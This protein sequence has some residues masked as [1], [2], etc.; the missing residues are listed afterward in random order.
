MA[1]SYVSVRCGKAT[2]HML[3]SREIAT[4]AWIVVKEKVE[5]TLIKLLF[6][7]KWGKVVLEN[8]ALFLGPTVQ[9]FTYFYLSSPILPTVIAIQPTKKE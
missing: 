9:L 1:G 4:P 5:H 2:H 3:T 6:I 8:I 7:N